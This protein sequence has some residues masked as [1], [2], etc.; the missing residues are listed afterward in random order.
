MKSM[1]SLI[2]FSFL[3][4]AVNCVWGQD[5]LYTEYF[6]DGSASLNWFSGWEGG[7]NMEI[8][9]WEGNPSGDNWVGFVGNDMTAQVGTA[10]AGSL[11]DTDYEFQAQVYITPG[12]GM[13]GPYKG[14]VARWDSV[15]GLGSFYSFRADFDASQ[16][17]QL[18]K[19]VGATGESIAEWTG[20]EIPGGVPTVDEWHLMGIK[21]EGNQI[22]VYWDGTELSGCPYTD[23]Q[24]SRGFFGL[25][26]FNMTGADEVYCDDII[27]LGDAGAQPFD[28]IAQDNHYLDEFLQEMTI[29]PAENQQIHFQLDWDAINGPGT[30]P[31]FDVKLEIDNIEIFTDNNPGVEPN[32]THETVSDAWTAT[33]GEHALRWTLDSGGTV[34]EGNEDNNELEESFLVLPEGS[35]DFSAD[36]AWVTDSDT[37]QTEPY[38]DQEVLFVLHWSTPMG[39][40]AS[41]AF[42]ITMDLDGEDFFLTTIPSVESGQTYQTV[43]SPWT[44]EL[45]FHYYEWTIDPDNW[46]DEFA[47]WNNMILEGF[48]VGTGP[49][50]WWDP[51]QLNASAEDF[52]ISS[53]Y[54]NPF[55]PTVALRYENIEPGI[56]KLSIFDVAGREIA[57][58]TDG[59]HP[60]GVWEVTWS[61]EEIAAGTYFA[62]LDGNGQRSVQPLLLVK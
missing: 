58:L 24:T 17:L 34:P 25:Y 51:S 9:Y 22:W 28:F 36:S 50:I 48:D 46:V 43:T 4:I 49:G 26:V 62:V 14:I 47:E 20:A 57:V 19:Y 21:F 30:S 18:R 37:I 12:G 33:L 52:K 3:L 2:V 1:K 54:P 16:R 8:D 39:T 6:T 60:A 5:T 7:N 31:A 11:N 56:L 35:F 38:V 13:M 29:R 53:V 42:N 59:F 15:G 55:N 44:A 27:V 61:G 32:S 41:G 23:S 10:L 40:G 45:G